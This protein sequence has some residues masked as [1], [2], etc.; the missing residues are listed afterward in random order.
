MLDHPTQGHETGERHDLVAV[1]D[2]GA[3]GAT[4]EK[5]TNTPKPP[6]TAPPRVDRMWARRLREDAQRPLSENL[7][8]GIALSHVLV[9]YASATPPRQ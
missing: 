3:I 1:S 2:I 8:E 9:R 5:H 6:T 4:V 7:A